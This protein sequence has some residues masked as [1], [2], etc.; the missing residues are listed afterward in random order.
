MKN[1]PERI[2]L[3]IQEDDIKEFNDFSVMNRRSVITWSECQIYDDD[4]EYVKKEYSWV[5][6]ND[7]LPPSMKRVLVRSEY[8]GESY[9]EVAFMMNGK[10]MC[11]NSTPTHWRPIPAFYK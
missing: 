2:F 11:H 7:S 4:I 5:N 8:E 6:V 9:F 3:N 1:I 10:W